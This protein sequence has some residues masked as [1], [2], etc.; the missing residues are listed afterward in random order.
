LSF[1]LKGQNRIAGATF[2]IFIIVHEAIFT[3][4]EGFVYFLSDALFSFAVISLLIT[5]PYSKLVSQLIT[6]CL[7]LIPLNL[8]S[9]RVWKTEAPIWFMNSLFAILYTYALILIGASNGGIFTLYKRMSTLFRRLGN[10]HNLVC[11]GFSMG[12]SLE[13]GK[14]P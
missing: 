5:Q 9:W 12:Q 14:K 11:Q 7:V 2:M 3:G 1:L 13:K 10:F 6:I 8:I 4:H